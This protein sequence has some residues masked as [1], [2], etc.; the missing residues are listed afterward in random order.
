MPSTESVLR[1]LALR[2][3]SRDAF[4]PTA[5]RYSVRLHVDHRF[6]Q[7]EP[8]SYILAQ[9]TI[10]NLAIMLAWFSR[11]TSV[12]EVVVI[13]LDPRRGSGHLQAHIPS[14]C[15]VVPCMLDSGDAAFIGHAHT[16]LVECAIEIKHLCDLLTSLED[17]RLPARQLI[18]MR[19]TYDYVFL[20]LHD[21]IACDPFGFLRVWSPK[22]K[23]KGARDS[24]ERKYDAPAY[25]TGHWVRVSYGVGR[26]LMFVD[27]WKWIIS[28]SV[29]GGIRLLFAGSNQEAGEVIAATYEELRKSPKE[30]KSLKV[31]DESHDTPLVKPS[32]AVEIA[33]RLVYNLG[34]ERSFAAAELFETP[35]GVVNASE[36]DWLKVP[37]VGKVLAQR[38]VKASNTSHVHR[39]IGGKVDDKRQ[40][41]RR[42]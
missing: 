3:R 30:R 39:T 4:Q 17:G 31:F 1:V 25:N 40:T 19:E 41:R 2:R 34:W 37:N 38:A 8:I 32:I 10:Q 29:D 21:R 28:L 22:E 9:W 11:S 20:L 24:G 18:G 26:N 15:K 27:F 16:G 33:H 5:L 12:D 36:A 13:R 6:L 42:R 35:R 7:T 23:H 14:R